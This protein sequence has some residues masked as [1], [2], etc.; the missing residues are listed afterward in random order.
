MRQDESKNPGHLISEKRACIL[1]IEMEKQFEAPEEAGGI[2][3]TVAR[4]GEGAK[5]LFSIPPKLRF[6]ATRSFLRLVTLGAG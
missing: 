1:M 4:S 6:L 3:T 2:M 5:T